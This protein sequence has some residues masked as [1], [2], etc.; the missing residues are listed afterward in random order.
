MSEIVVLG[1]VLWDLYP[2]TPTESLRTRRAEVRCLGGAPANVACTLARLGV[3]V[4]MIAAVGDDALGEAARDELH[5]AGVDV[6]AVV[7]V[8]ARTGIT[9]VELIDG[10]PR[11]L[12]F[13]SPSADMLLPTQAVPD[14]EIPLLH[15]GSSSFATPARDATLLAI[16]RARR[17]SIDL[18]IYPFLFT[19]GL[20]VLDDVLV[21]A[22]LVKASETD[23]RALGLPPDRTG[24]AMLHARRRD[25]I[26][27]AT[28]GSDGAVAFCGGE[29]LECRMPSTPIIDAAGAGDAFTAGVLATVVRNGTLADALSLGARLGARA[30]TAIGATT[31]LRDLTAERA[32]LDA[33]R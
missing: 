30:V 18:N 23:L 9:F 2:S 15:V 4:A 20:G 26:T 1:E 10:T 17:V 28:F 25:G 16:S 11:F 13:R 7:P 6:S 21:R 24:A 8:R 29:T 27:L 22:G 14:A 12:P 5:E 3:D 19:A 31:A 32:A 33:L